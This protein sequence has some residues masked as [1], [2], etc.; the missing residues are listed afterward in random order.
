M[1][2]PVAELASLVRKHQ[3]GL[4]LDTNVLL[5]HLVVTAAPD[6]AADWKHSKA[7]GDLGP[8]LIR[9]A[10][11]N[12]R[13]L[14]TTPHLLTE[15]SDLAE[16]GVSGARR[17]SI[18]RALRQFA[19][20]ATERYTKS[21]ELVGDEHFVRLGLADVA[22]A[23][24]RRHRATPLVLTSDARVA[25]ELERRRLPVVNFMHYAYPIA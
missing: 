7:F 3:P 16:Q 14:L 25:V 9:A 12:A 13:R 15:A 20:D 22:Q 1:R 18:A 17:D 2:D 4:V 6:F 10:T 21:R 23:H 24:L 19:T 5:L 8:T 11:T